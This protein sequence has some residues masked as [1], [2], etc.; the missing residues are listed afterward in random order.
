MASDSALIYVV[1][2]IHFLLVLKFWACDLISAIPLSCLYSNIWLCFH[3]KHLVIIFLAYMTKLSSLYQHWFG[4]SLL[5]Y[6]LLSIDRP[7][8]RM[9][10]ELFFK[11]KILFLFLFVVGFL[12]SLLLQSLAAYLI[13][14][15]ISRQMLSIQYFD[16]HQTYRSNAIIKNENQVNHRLPEGKKWSSCMPKVKYDIQE[17]SLPCQNS[18]RCRRNFYM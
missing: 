3:A 7:V 4:I 11:R 16:Q 10:I 12:S 13:S 6:V 14:K 1:N 18:S 17:S 15:M 2:T 5:N 9:P 8:D